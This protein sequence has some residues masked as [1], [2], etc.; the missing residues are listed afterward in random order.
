MPALTD[1]RVPP[2]DPT[3]ENLLRTKLE[4]IKLVDSGLAVPENR[5]FRDLLPASILGPA[6]GPCRGVL[7]ESRVARLAGRAPHGGRIAGVS[8]RCRSWCCSVVTWAG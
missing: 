5:A 2:D 6:F 8:G 4:S 7:P 1:G 3:T